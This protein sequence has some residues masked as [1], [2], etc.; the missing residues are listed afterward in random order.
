[1]PPTKT[2]AMSALFRKGYRGRRYRHRINGF[3]LIE[4][5]CV[6]AVIS[7]LGAIIIAA[8]SKSREQSNAIR[9]LSNLRQL[10]T[11]TLLYVND[12]QGC[13][14]HS[15]EISETGSWINPLQEACLSA[16]VPDDS[17]ATKELS[18]LFDPQA[19]EHHGTVSDYGCN[20]LLFQAPAYDRVHQCEL[21]KPADTVMYVTAHSV[22]SGMGAWFIGTQAYINN[23]DNQTGPNPC[24]WGT[25]QYLTVHADGHAASYSIEE[26]KDN[27]QTLL[28][29][30]R[31]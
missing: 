7:I 15:R 25:G 17:S 14:P 19:E 11:A 27:R 20:T 26:F 1:M 8:V 18:V 28:T 16:Y 5:L 3:S 6:I 12:N 2:K 9:S 13:F 30:D 24:D 10:G 31:N 4:L 22:S 21:N 23:P 29:V